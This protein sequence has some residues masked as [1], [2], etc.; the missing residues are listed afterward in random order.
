MLRATQKHRENQSCRLKY[1]DVFQM[2]ATRDGYS[3]ERKIKTTYGI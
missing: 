3:R 2:H 1:F